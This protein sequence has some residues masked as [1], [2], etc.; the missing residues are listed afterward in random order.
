MTKNKL[1]LVDGN[2]VAFRA[3]FAL[4]N[5]L[6]RFKNKNGL[7]TNAVY[8]FNNMFEN[9]M[10]KEN[11]T[12]VLVA[13][14]AGKTTFR[15]EFYPEYKAG[16]SKTPGEFKEQMPYIRELLTGLG[17]KYYELDNYEA[18][19]IIGT[20]ATKVPKEE[21]D[22]VVL[23]GDRD[24]TQ[25]A[26]DSVKVDITVKGVSDLESYTPAHVA[27]KYDGLTPNQIIDMKGLAGDTSDN[28]PGVTKIGEKTAIKLL[29]EYG[30]VEGVYENID[31]LKPSK[32]K[33]NLINDKEQA[34]MSKRLA[35]IN[36]DSPV[37]LDI[38]ELK[39]EGKDLDKLIPFYK[40]MEF[41]QML[42][43]LNVEEETV[44]LEDVH[45][46]VV[47]TFTSEMFTDD[48]ALYVEMLEDN[49]HTSPIVG[50]AWGNKK[51][52]YVTNSLSLFESKPFVEWVLSDKYKKTVY[53]AKR[54]YV[55]LNRYVGKPQ[56]ITFDVLLAAYLLD[57]N[58]N[59]ADIEGVAQHYG[60]TDIHS[61]ESVYGKGAKKGLPEEDEAFFSHL[62]RK[63]NAIDFLSE[64]LDAELVEKNQADLFYKME[65]PLSKILGDMEITGIRVDANRLKEMR[66][67]FSD[68]LRE[69]EQKIYAEAGE[70]FNLNSPKQ[71]GVILFEKMGLPVIKKTKT[72]YSTAV[73]VLEQLKE[74]APIVEDILVY[75][76]IAKIQ[77]TYVEGLLKVIQPDDK[78]HT[79]YVQTLT[80]TGRLSSVDPNL[81]NIPIR[82]DEGRKIRQAFVPREK[83]WLIF[84]S[85]YS[86][87]ELRV[88]AHISDDKHLKEAFIEGQDI[89]SSTAMRVFGIEKP[90]EVTPNMRRQAK[91][92]NF[93]IVYGIS[94]YGLSQNLGIT[95]KQAQEYIDTYF[96][97]YPGV[98]TYM[99]DIVRDAKDKGFVETLY[100]RRRYLPDINSRNFNLRSFA[101]RTAINTP[102]QG[103]A[104][105]ILK[106]AMI[107]MQERLKEE[108][109]QATM[110]LQVHDELV[111]EAPES[112]LDKLNA[113][114]KDVMENAV[115]LHVPLLT[116]SSWG[117][118]WYEAK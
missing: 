46:D 66:I 18:D 78:I 87:I 106:I 116:D 37:K 5:S 69:I 59:S 32:M 26:T 72:G 30:S 82:L 45:F 31:N 1:L 25:L 84:S 100:N 39:Y 35:T 63:V 95:R 43:K 15:T 51:K 48:M 28:I 20:L 117:K 97:K 50:V 96:E 110:L 16:R 77:S 108:K 42:S 54:T 57:T 13:F 53:D 22:V 112:E 79:R 99:E 29:K 36:V 85:D 81:Q 12:H 118:T 101:E 68:R 21:F 75:R 17:V 92:V 11:P 61:D 65:L 56:G 44:E 55:S 8:A 9:V 41:K 4:H 3:F 94:D 107:N 115:Q 98:K 88:L 52:V 76:Q 70:E 10:E 105:D 104:A 47:D 6:E 64:K 93:G 91:A 90:E 34:F 103:S 114:V 58:D 67:E 86:Q 14:D 113:L 23:S 73:D 40:E 19:D 49:Y 27:E 71:L 109:M 60:Y 111:F 83:D 2:S 89:H 33:E 74:Q 7:H 24:L 62:A 80:Q 38:D 102:I